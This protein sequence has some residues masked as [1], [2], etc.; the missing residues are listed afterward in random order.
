MVKSEQV[1]T[2]DKATMNC[3]SPPSSPV[4]QDNIR[5][6]HS[7]LNLKD[8][9]LCSDDSSSE[10]PSSLIITNIDVRVF[11]DPDLKASFEELFKKYEEDTTFQYF[12]SFRRARVN[13]QNQESA[14]KAKVHC[15]QSQFGENLI[16]CYYAQRSSSKESDLSDTH[17]QPPTPEKQFLI[18]PP[19]SPPPGWEP[20]G[21]A[22]P[23][24]NY[25]L[26]SAIAD[27]TP[28]G[29]H[30]LHPPSTSQPGIV[31]H[32]CEQKK[33]KTQPKLKIVHTRCPGKTP[34]LDE[35]ESP[36]PPTSTD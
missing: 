9:N 34:S 28:G 14:A 21:E 19:A 3:T 26:L 15:H 11:S 32:V 4:E 1:L 36:S 33:E 20:V 22:Q 25:D 17:L 8:E 2:E 27:L 7:V 30:E 18:S 24:I 23:A 5:E 16:N 29:V 31:V 13:Y 6:G 35:M 12:K 10:L